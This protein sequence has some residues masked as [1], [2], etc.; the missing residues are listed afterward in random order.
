MVTG[1]LKQKE[2]SEFVV[3][4]IKG[5]ADLTPRRKGVESDNRE[6]DQDPEALEDVPVLHEE[7]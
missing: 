1:I 7:L 4:V 2:L 5:K 3:S 6:P